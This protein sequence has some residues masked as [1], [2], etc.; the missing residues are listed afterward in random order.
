MANE[1]VVGTCAL[2]KYNDQLYELAKMGVSEAYQGQKIGRKLAEAVLERAKELG[3][4]KVF[5]ESSQQLEAA[6]ALYHK[7]GFRPDLGLEV[8]PFSRCNVQLALNL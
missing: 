7:L 2:I 8:S 3:A 4:K 5:L 1:K 6:L